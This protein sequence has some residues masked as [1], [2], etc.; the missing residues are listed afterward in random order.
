MAGPTVSLG[1]K[2]VTSATPVQLTK[3]TRK[4]SAEYEV[5]LRP[6]FYRSHRFF[7][8]LLCRKE[9]LCLLVFLFFLFW[10][11]FAI[12]GAVHY[13]KWYPSFDLKDVHI[14][15]F[16]VTPA[17]AL[18]YDMDILIEARRFSPLRRI[19]QYSY[20]IRTSHV[21]TAIGASSIPGF[22]PIQSEIMELTTT[23]RVSLLPLGDELGDLVRKDLNATGRLVIRFYIEGQIYTPL[24]LA[25][26]KRG[27]WTCDVIVSPAA[28]FGS[29]IIE[30]MCCKDFPCIREDWVGIASPYT[31]AVWACVKD[32]PT[33]C[34]TPPADMRSTNKIC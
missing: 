31:S 28:P 25:M 22:H 13:H 12:V 15:S 34:P 32:A 7:R 23:Q 29:Q 26:K 1:N 27:G 6:R 24:F 3:C 2:N 11:L 8:F 20:E 17:R 16:N 33:C 30:R 5:C 4:P 21:G 19:E 14:R 10:S 9:G 18:S